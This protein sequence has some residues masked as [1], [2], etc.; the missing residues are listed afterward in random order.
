MWAFLN[1]IFTLVLEDPFEETLIFEVVDLVVDV[2]GL[3]FRL[4]LEDLE[5]PL[6]E[7]VIF[8]EIDLT[9]VFG[10][11]FGVVLEMESL[12]GGFL[13]R[14]SVSVREERLEDGTVVFDCTSVEDIVGRLL[15]QEQISWKVKID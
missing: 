6:E 13:R 7:R 2:V 5:D 11:S 4:T 1:R 14:G 12:F 10:L 8:E 15:E 3:I 9:D